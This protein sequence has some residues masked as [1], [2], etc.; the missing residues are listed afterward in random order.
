MTRT[1]LDAA[2]LLQ[3]VAGYDMIDDRQLG[4]PLPANVPRY[5]ELLLENR[6]QG[7]KGLRI[8]LL[9]EGF[10]SNLLDAT[11]NETCRSAIRKLEGLGGVVEEVSVPL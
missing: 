7:V 2:V 8:G 6:K 5:S 4:V 10:V 1:A 3:A 11:V 9:R